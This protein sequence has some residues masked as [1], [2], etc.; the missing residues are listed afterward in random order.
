MNKSKIVLIAIGGTTL[1]ASLV[2]LFFVYTAS[3]AKTAALEGDFDEGTD[4]L[5][6]VMAKAT[7]LS[8]K[9]VFPCKKSVDAYKAN[10][11]KFDEWRSEALNVAS[12]GDRTFPPTTSAAFKEFLLSESRRLSSLPGGVSGVLIKPEFAFG[13]FKEYIL[14]GKLPPEAKLQELQRQWDDIVFVTEAIAKAGA[15]EL[16]SLEIKSSAA[17]Q[18]ESESVKAKKRPGKRPRPAK[19]QASGEKAKAEIFKQSYTFTFRARPAAFV[20][21]LNAMNVC[22]RFVTVDSFSFV[23]ES[24]YLVEALSVGKKDPEERVA[25]RSARSSRAARRR[26][27]Q[28]EETKKVESPREQALR[29]GIVS[30]PDLDSP[31]LVTVSLTIRDFGTLSAEGTKSEKTGEEEK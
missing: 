23:K 21:V 11:D 10:R 16:T 8:R 25:K 28:E 17:K 24:D 1:V 4:G 22:D 26:A 15:L 29:L 31:L 14:D 13:P 9:S 7:D 3:S 30:D 27:A 18:E 12:R 19:K 5:S 20:S 6:T 2:A